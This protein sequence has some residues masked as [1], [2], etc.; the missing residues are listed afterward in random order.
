MVNEGDVNGELIH[1]SSFFFSITEGPLVQLV[2][3]GKMH[4]LHESYP[5]R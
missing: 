1:K 3:E 5:S 4:T 2:L